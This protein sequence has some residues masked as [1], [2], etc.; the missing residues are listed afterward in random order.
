MKHKK[1]MDIECLAGKNSEAFSS[2]D[3]III[4]E[5]IDGANAAIRYDSETNKVVAQSRKQM[6]SSDNG[7][8]GFYEW[9]QTLD[10]ALVKELLG[11]NLIL[12]CEWLVPH[13][14]KYPEERYNKAY[15]YDVYD[16]LAER[17]LPQDKV[18][19]IVDKLGLIYVPVFYE[20]P[21]ISWE[22]CMEFVGRTELGGDHGEGIV[23][24]NMT[25][26]NDANSRLPFY[27]KIVGEKFQEVHKCKEPKVVDLD[28]IR[29][30]AA[31]I[32]IVETVVTEARVRKLLNKMVDEGSLVEDWSYKDI[33]SIAKILPKEVYNDCVKEEPD[34]V[35][36]VENFG[37][38]AAKITMQLVN[39]I[40]SEG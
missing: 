12:F 23:V 34:T 33:Q 10:V 28:A 5:K 6:L 31:D 4:Q 14:L 24:K 18:K 15:C 20:G 8:R 13:T 37:K 22:H 32:Q 3:S 38:V 29:Q 9:T 25:R 11:D 27:V 36:R 21:F 40:A 7:L 26:L 16:T 35:N 30:R 1:F 2:D 17:Y 39:K 19:E